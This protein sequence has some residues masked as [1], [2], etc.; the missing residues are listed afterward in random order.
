[1]I[2]HKYSIILAISVVGAGLGAQGCVATGHPMAR[3]TELELNLIGQGLT[4]RPTFVGDRL[5]YPAGL[6]VLGLTPPEDEP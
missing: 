2:K 4:Q 1:M 6:M 5:I 3:L